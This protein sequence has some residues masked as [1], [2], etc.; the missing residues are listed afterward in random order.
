[1]ARP[2]LFW[3]FWL[4]WKTLRWVYAF[5]AHVQDF[6]AWSI[7]CD[8]PRRL[9]RQRRL[10][11][12]GMTGLHLTEQQWSQASCGFAHAGLELRSS[13][14]HAPAAYLSSL[15]ASLAGCRE[16]DPQFN[17]AE[18]L[19][20]LEVLAALEAF[21]AQLPQAQRLT[22][23]AAVALKQR[24]LSQLLDQAAWDTQ[25]A[26]ATPSERAVL[27]SEA[28][29]GARAFLAALPSGRTR[30]ETASFVAEL[31]FRLGLPDAAEDTW[32]PRCDAFLDRFSHHA[33]SCV[34]GGERTLRHHAIH[35][36]VF[37]WAQRAALHPE[38]ERPGLLLPQSPEDM[39]AAG[40]RP[41][42]LYLPAWLGSPVA[43]DFAVTAPQRQA[44]LA[45]AS[46]QAGAAA[47]AY[48][49]HKEDHLG[50]AAACA[51]Q[52][53][54][55]V[56]LVVETTGHWEAGASRVLKQIAGAVAARTGTE[57]GPLHDSLLQ[58][59][60]VVVRS[61]RA[62]AALRRRAELEA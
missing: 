14:R 1:M 52:G 13:A 4:R 28:G 16:L 47:E 30:M 20:S 32:C 42:D 26:R 61:F 29:L 2:Q 45:Q 39:R 43:F 33:A 6:A 5:S 55:F 54:Q 34:A 7:A 38:R 59:L 58:E 40:R 57:P 23:A 41:A 17:S 15:G 53:V 62:R 49:R 48:A 8:V 3:T 36:T 25:L 11:L 60:S 50:T 12:L 46:M 18:V 56:P 10:Q 24:Q 19:A 44:T 37:T 22:V 31:R 51:E 9:L 35:D 21:N 27:R